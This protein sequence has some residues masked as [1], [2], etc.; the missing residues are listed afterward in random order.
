M[1]YKHEL[2]QEK[3]DCQATDVVWGWKH[4]TTGKPLPQAGHMP[5][6]ACPPLPLMESLPRGCPS[7]ALMGAHPGLL[8][9]ALDTGRLDTGSNN[10]MQWIRET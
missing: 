2:I 5:A 4:Q 6:V 9:E 8:G 3:D 10:H 1:L 7:A